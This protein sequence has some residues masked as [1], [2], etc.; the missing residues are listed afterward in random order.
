MAV[1]NW[2]GNIDF[3]GEL[4]TPASV[5]AVRERVADAAPGSL[6]PLGTRHSF[7][8]IADTSGTLLSSAAFADPARIRLAPDR[9]SVSAPGGIRYGEL[10]R[11]L[12]AEGLALANLASLPH[13]SVAGAV[14]TG[15][16]GSGVR[17]GSLAAAV[18]GIEFVDGTGTLVTSRRGEPHFDGSVV[19]LG[20]L[21]FTTRLELDIE[22]S[23]RVAQT[24]YRCLPLDAALDSFEQ[25]TALG[26][27]VSLFTT[28][29]DPDVIDQLWLK[30]RV[31]RDAPAPDAVLGAAASATPMHPIAGVDPVHCT[32]QLGEPGPWL[33]RLPHFKLE[34]TPSNGAELQTEYL[35]PRDTAVAALREVRSLADDIRPLLQV[36]EIRE[37]AAD[38]L[39]LSGAYETDAVGIHF[40]WRPEQSAVDALL[41]RLEERLL[42]L[43]ARPHWGKRFHADAAALAP[44]YPRLDDFRALVARHDPRGV[45]LNDFLRAK[46]GL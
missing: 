26:Y 8:P 1:Q 19:A 37:I 28:W 23:Y 22:P 14:A 42:P 35:L 13:I 2:A 17:N 41:P 43:G 15:T 39:W 32:P 21:G 45:F 29:A 12:E 33:D 31:D 36:T 3:A 11:A 38:T 46:L 27:S 4:A 6:R 34:F 5:D 20:A 44:L 18:R 7:S 10:A 9:A 30:R 16:H 40:T 25:I 24:V